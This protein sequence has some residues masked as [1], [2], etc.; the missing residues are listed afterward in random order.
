MK[1]IFK[2]ILINVVLTLLLVG[3]FYLIL[4]FAHLM[5]FLLGKLS[6]KILTILIFAAIAIG[7]ILAGKEKL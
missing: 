3:V 6:V 1:Q 5:L 4:G 7:L 2:K